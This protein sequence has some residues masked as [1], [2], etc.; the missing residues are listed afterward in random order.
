MVIKRWKRVIALFTAIT[1]ILAGAPGVPRMA[2]ADTEDTT[3][4][5]GNAAGESSEEGDAAKEEEKQTVSDDGEVVMDGAVGKK[6]KSEWITKKDYE[7]VAE[8]DTYKMYLYEPR[9]SIMLE[10]KNTGKI[11]ESTLSDEKDDGN[12]NAG[13]NAYMKSG[14]VLT[15]IIGTKN[16][17]QVDL[18]TVK[19]TVNVTKT[20]NGFSANIHFD[21]PYQFDLTVNVS[22]ENDNLVV[23]VPDDSIKEGKEGTYISTISLFPFMGYSFLDEEEG[24]MLV[25][26]GNGALINLDNKE[27]R[28]TTGFSQMIY[29]SDVGFSDSVT[30]KKLWEE[31]D[32]ADSGIDMLQDANEVVAPIFGMAH[33]KSQKGYLAIVE[34]GEKR[35]NIVAEPNGVTVN[36]NRCYARFL[37]RDVYVQ[38]LNNS[39]S[40][41][42]QMAEKDRV[43]SDFQVRYVLLSGDEANY[44]SMAIKYRNYLLDNKLITKKD[45]K[46]NTR[47]DF[48]GT[49]RE[50]FLLGTRAVTMTRTKDVEKIYEELQNSGVSTLLSVYKGWQDG[51]LYN[52]P[53]SDYDAD[54]HI[55]GTSDLTDLIKE[56]AEKNYQVYLYNDVL[57]LNPS[58]HNLNFNMIKK[59]NKRTYDEEIWA[60]VYEDFYYLTPAT[61]A[62]YFED[63]VDDVTD[64]ELSK[65]AVSGVSNTLYTYSYKGDFYTRNDTAKDYSDLLA[66]A[67][68]KADLILEKPC[69]YLW[70]NTDAFLDMPLGSSDYMYVD[71]E[72]PFLSMVLKGIIP[73]YSDYV[74]FEANKNEFFLQ[75]IE[76]GVYPSFYLTYENS[77]KLI[78][79]NSADMYST[80]YSTYKDMI[81][82]Y[83]KD[84]RKVN[85]VIGD[86]C[87]TKHE[88]MENG[89][90]V[91]TY[92]NGVKIYVNYTEEAQTLDGITVEAMSYSYKAGEAE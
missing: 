18:I 47:V 2:S 52:V 29:G 45:T 64:E 22:L 25:P 23:N 24:Y 54:S 46:Y 10:N 31:E 7:L 39:K 26:D 49:D 16:T 4:E 8:S 90:T 68:E 76:S 21:E 6:D 19:N 59:V 17:Y 32:N 74:N 50:D 51:G 42:M 34:K 70:N 13:W 78:Y 88:K 58:T 87:I 55:G 80:E 57:R 73:M 67:D 30:R 92:S 20:D 81:A 15:A 66:A 65:I 14:I 56:S 61:S 71:D 43:H 85:E 62:S 28:Y 35:A 48:L 82:E 12:S 89:V 84:L 9:L 27:G 79:T 44:S 37:L 69:A 36:Y 91:V 77:S 1:V 40:G 86:A 60:E 3:A 72:I 33:T 5:D 63:F 38:P 53:I 83:D 11:I 75:M 41:T